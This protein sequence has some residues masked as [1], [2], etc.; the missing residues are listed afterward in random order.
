MGWFSVLPNKHNFKPNKIKFFTKN[1]ISCHGYFERNCLYTFNDNDDYDINKLIG[2]S[3]S[4]H[5]MVQSVRIGWRPSKLIPGNIELLTYVHDN[6]SV[7][8]TLMKVVM[9]DPVPKVE[10]RFI[11]SVKPNEFFDLEIIAQDDFYIFKGFKET[12]FDNKIEVLVPKKKRSFPFRYL[13]TPYF[14]GN[15]VAPKEME[16]WLTFD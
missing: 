15:R 1:S 3:T 8:K 13:L 2:F 9:G 12:D 16:I 6:E 7:W 11:L 10:E 5:H 4:I 14:G